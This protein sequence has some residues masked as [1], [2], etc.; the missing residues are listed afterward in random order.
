MERPQ[1]GCHGQHGGGYDRCQDGHLAWTLYTFRSTNLDLM[2]LTSGYICSLL[3]FCSLECQLFRIHNFCNRVPF[4]FNI[5]GILRV[6]WALPSEQGQQDGT[7]DATRAQNLRGQVQ[8]PWEYT[9]G[10]LFLTIPQ[11]PPA[12]HPQEPPHRSE[13]SW[14]RQTG[15][16]LLSGNR[17]KQ[18][19]ND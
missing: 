9:L 2:L 13:G 15:E 6:I 11:T 5:P 4:I 10:H 14:R 3:Y 7:S 1:P 8:G 19:E 18:M 12:L 17:G 16:K